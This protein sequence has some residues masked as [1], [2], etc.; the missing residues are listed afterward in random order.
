MLA[1]AVCNYIMGLP[2]ADDI[3]LAYQS[4]CFH[5]TLYLR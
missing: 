4:T 2:G 1:V 3:M 5:D